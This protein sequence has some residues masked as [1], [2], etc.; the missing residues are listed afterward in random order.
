VVDVVANAVFFHGAQRALSEQENP[1][2]TRMSFAAAEENFL[3]GARRGMDAK[4]YW[5]G[6]GWIAPD[7]L[8]LRHLLP[9][10]HEGLRSCGVSDAVRERHLGVIE[11]RCLRR[12]TGSS[13]Q[14]EMVAR[15]DQRG[16][17]ESALAHMLHRYLELTATEEPVHTWP[18]EA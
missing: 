10:A 4:L 3:A 11:Q 15:L 18:I 17:R 8:V 2:W 16:D 1:L 7:E 12:Q 14:R 5:P 13:W 9:M 6:E